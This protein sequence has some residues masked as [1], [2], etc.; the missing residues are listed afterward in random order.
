MTQKPNAKD[1]VKTQAKEI[2]DLRR[3]YNMLYEEKTSLVEENL[4]LSGRLSLIDKGPETAGKAVGD[5]VIDVGLVIEHL[6]DYRNLIKQVLTMLARYSDKRKPIG[7]AYFL[8][9]R[10][11]EAKATEVAKVIEWVNKCE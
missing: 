5:R 7:I 3:R 8:T 6:R 4:Q 9:G 2:A 10:Y 1:I 11:L